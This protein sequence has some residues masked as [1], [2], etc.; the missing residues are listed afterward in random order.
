M[1]E[2]VPLHFEMKNESYLRVGGQI[3]ALHDIQLALIINIDETG[4]QLINVAKRRTFA[5][6]GA[7][8]V[9]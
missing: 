1:R 6:K 3:L 8:R 9:R 2:T 5:K 7:K 4:A